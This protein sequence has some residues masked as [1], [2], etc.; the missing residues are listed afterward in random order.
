[1][2]TASLT[3]GIEHHESFPVLQVLLDTETGREIRIT[4]KKDQVMEEHQTPFP[5]VVEIFEGSIAF[6]VQ[7][8]IKIL[9][10]G[11]LIALGGNIPHDL[12]AIQQSI[13]RLSLNK[14]NAAEQIEDL[15]KN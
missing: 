15:V 12:K 9:K 10:K 13:L 11:D 2:K 4:F 6:G 8:R 1:M 5:I 3:N 14:A 7:G